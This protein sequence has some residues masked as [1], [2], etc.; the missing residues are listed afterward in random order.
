MHDWYENHYNSVTASANGSV[1]QS[2]MHKAMETPFPPTS[3]FERVLEVGGNRGEHL[4]FVRHTH[5]A[6]VISDLRPPGL[7][8][9][10][11]GAG[12]VMATCC[13]A[14]SLPHPAET[15]DRVLAT[16]LF[17]HVVDPL[18]VATEMRRVTRRGGRITILIP[19]DPSLAY[20]A[21]VFATSRRNAARFGLKEQMY[22]VKALDHRNHYRSIACQLAHVFRRD[23][24]SIAYRPLRVPSVELNA[25]AVWQVART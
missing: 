21:G 15:F 5:D 4:Q 14:S 25:F 11:R 1:F 7:D 22:L 3:H 23:G 13:D 2:Y 6:Y 10:P 16:C 20:R 18:R 24:V 12:R 8:F 17:H 19:T 9:T